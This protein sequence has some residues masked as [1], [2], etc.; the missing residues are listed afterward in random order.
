M[1]V[2]EPLPKALVALAHQTAL[3]IGLVAAALADFLPPML[4][5]S[6]LVEGTA[7]LL[8]GRGAGPCERLF[9]EAHAISIRYKPVFTNSLTLT[10]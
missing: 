5:R 9:S 6:L 7:I 3:A 4:L 1:P 2:P 8:Q 10:S